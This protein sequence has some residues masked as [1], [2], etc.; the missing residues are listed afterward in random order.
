M[1]KKLRYHEA[2]LH[3]RN[4][5]K[6]TEETTI[7]NII[8]NSELVLKIF[9]HQFCY[10]PFVDERQSHGRFLR[11][12]KIGRKRKLFVGNKIYFNLAEDG[13]QDLCRPL[14]LRVPIPGQMISGTF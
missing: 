10:L 4:G 2:I 11:I 14:S 5:R 1:D 13:P 7:Q 6:I 9:F 8:E 3:G 12:L